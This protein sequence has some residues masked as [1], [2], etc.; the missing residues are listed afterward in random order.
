MKKIMVATDLSERSDRAVRRA[1]LLAKQTGARLMLIHVVDDD[2]PARIVESEQAVAG[3]LLCRQSATLNSVDGVECEARIVLAYAFAGIA[4]AA[5]E[6]A[7]DLLVLGP[8]RRQ[9]LRDVFVGTTA[10]RTLRSVSCPVLMAIAPPV[11]AYRHAMLATDLSEDAR[12]AARSFEGLR[13]ASPASSSILHVFDAP[14]L[15]RTLNHA[16][17]E[18]EKLAHLQDMRRDADRALAGFIKDLGGTWGKRIVTRRMEPVAREIL[19]V[20]NERNADLIVMG[21]RRTGM[22]KFLLGSV[23][24]QVVRLSTHDVLAIP[25]CCRD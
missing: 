16:V 19:A 5:E 10:E 11:G 12:H 17:G 13:I 24:E 6:I 23:A 22:E 4:R 8:H 18:E 15:R 3:D 14:E 21:T 2:Q 9:A 1:V 7:P 25:P 20:S